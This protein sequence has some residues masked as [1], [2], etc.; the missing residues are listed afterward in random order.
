M[1][2]A[3]QW[4]RHYKGGV[5]RIRMLACLEDSGD[6]AVIYQS[7]TFGT[8][9]VRPLSNFLG[10]AKDVGTSPAPRRFRRVGVT[11]VLVGSE[12]PKGGEHV[13]CGL[14]PGC[15]AMV[16]VKVKSTE[17]MLREMSPIG[18]NVQTR[19]ARMQ[20][21]EDEARQWREAASTA[22][23]KAMEAIAYRDLMQI[24]LE[25]RDRERDLMQD[26]H[27]RVLRLNESL[28]DG[29][30]N[31]KDRIVQLEDALMR[32][33]EEQD[34]RVAADVDHAKRSIKQACMFAVEAVTEPNDL[35]GDDARAGWSAGVKASA[36]AIMSIDLLE[37]GGG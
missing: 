20:D 11:E 9:W 1:P 19:A 36:D 21:L 8:V 4:Y 7:Q 37:G 31:A 33:A 10:M 27:T 6:L 5:Y 32:A 16:I 28:S 14:C 12:C 26:E 15:E 35:S 24:E 17:E 29:L 34:A 13:G 3:D 25:K 22:D 30:V 2:E 23:R 18:M